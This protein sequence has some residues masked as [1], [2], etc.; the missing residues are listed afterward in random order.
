MNIIKDFIKKQGIGVWISVGAVVLSIV[1]LIIYS[2]ALAKG[3]GLSIANGSEPFYKLDRKAD[4]TMTSTVVVCGVVS[5][6]LLVVA[7]A[8]AQFKLGGI[9][10]T[11]RDI[12]IGACRIVA[13]MLILLAFVNFVYGSFTGL[14]WTF[15]SNPELRIEAAATAV[16][17]QVITGAIFFALAGVAGIVAAFFNLIKKEEGI[18]A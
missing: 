1:A 7:I 2:L 4:M 15:F 8:G 12:A 14:G 3:T 18:E 17:N 13:P 6:A 9:L 16:G 5:L 11:I 10:G